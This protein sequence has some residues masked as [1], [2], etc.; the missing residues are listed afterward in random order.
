M[1]FKKSVIIFLLLMALIAIPISYANDLDSS[2]VNSNQ[3][4][5]NNLLINQDLDENINL[6]SN[7][8]DKN[9]EY[10]LCKYSGF[11]L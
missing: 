9:G 10:L 7:P 3:L 1:K 4:S 8:D 2:D 11:P 6:D 5:D